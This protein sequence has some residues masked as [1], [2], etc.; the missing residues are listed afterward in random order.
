MRHCDVYFVWTSIASDIYADIEFQTALVG[1]MFTRVD[2]TQKG[3]VRNHDLV[4]HVPYTYLCIYT[5]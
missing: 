4:S 5:K 2:F 3:T 1:E